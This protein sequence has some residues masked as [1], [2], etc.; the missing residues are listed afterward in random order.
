MAHWCH[1]DAIGGNPTVSEYTS[2]EA[3]RH[4]RK[5]ADGKTFFD[6]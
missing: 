5:R 6:R 1:V 4:R 2:R 3:R